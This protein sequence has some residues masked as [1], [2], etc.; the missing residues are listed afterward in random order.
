M[1]EQIKGVINEK[2]FRK[3]YWK[4]EA[5]GMQKSREDFIK[6]KVKSPMCRKC[7]HTDFH[8]GKAKDWKEYCDQKKVR[9]T[10][11]MDVNPKSANFGRQLGVTYDF[12]CPKRHK[13]SISL[14]MC[15]VDEGKDKS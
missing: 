7:F 6:G 10:K 15:E 13:T 8:N 14:L 2:A 1:A 3:K 4:A 9:T 5:E 12:V 11:D